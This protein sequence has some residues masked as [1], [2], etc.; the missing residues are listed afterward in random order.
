MRFHELI[1]GG[2]GGGGSVYW[3]LSPLWGDFGGRHSLI[4]KYRE[5][6][7]VLWCGHP[8]FSITDASLKVHAHSLSVSLSWGSDGC[9]RTFFFCRYTYLALSLQ[10]G[11]TKN[12]IVSL[13]RYSLRQSDEAAD[14]EQHFC[15]DLA[16]SCYEFQHCR[17]WSDAYYTEDVHDRAAQPAGIFTWLRDPHLSLAGDGWYIQ[18]TLVN[19]TAIGETHTRSSA[20]WKEIMF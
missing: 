16:I 15:S 19:E 18:G 7:A 13:Q 9:R 4:H 1:M 2:G 3:A 8:S 17:T 12:S 10:D 20:G 11:C 5:Y 14:E 6:G